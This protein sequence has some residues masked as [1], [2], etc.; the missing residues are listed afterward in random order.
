MDCRTPGLPVPHH[1]PEFAQVHVHC[2]SDA[3]QLSLPLTP[4]PFTLN[5]SQHQELF[6]V[7]HPFTSD[8]QNTGASASASVLPV[9][10]EY[11]GFISLK[12][13]WFDLL[14]VQVTQ[15]S[16]PA[17]QLESISSSLVAQMVKSLPAMQETLVRSQGWED[18][19]E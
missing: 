7:S 13:D 19:L 8:D 5:L 15:E 9:N 4:S 2:I 10:S 1:L 3:V 14:A 11:S 16:S 17:P 12:M 6:Q 18:P